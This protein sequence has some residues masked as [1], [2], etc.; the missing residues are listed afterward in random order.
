M[1]KEDLRKIIQTNTI[2]IEALMNSAL[3]G[4]DARQYKAILSRLR[5]GQAP[6]WFEVLAKHGALPNLD[7]KTIGSVIEA[8]LVA[9]IETHILRSHD[10][11][12]LRINPA[13][14]VDLPD[15]DLGVKS[16][17]TNWCT[18]EPFFSAY[19]RL[20]GSEYD[21][22]ILLTNYQTAKKSPPLKLQILSTN[23][24]IASEIADYG[25]C[26]IAKKFR[27]EMVGEFNSAFE[28]RFKQLCTFL[29]YVN[30][31]DWRGKRLLGLIPLIKNP[32]AIKT[33]IRMA[34]LDF[35]RKSAESERK[36]SPRIP[37]S[38]L[39]ALNLILKI[40]P[41]SIGV[42]DALAQWLMDMIKDAARPPNDN[43][44]KRLLSGPLCGKI[45]MSFALQW[46]YNFKK[47]FPEIKRGK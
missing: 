29:A 4:S 33:S 13:R 3:S 23:Y 15:L 26:R 6:H 24:L 30:Q 39:D 17:S 34:N 38:D 8:L 28:F 21:A 20:T 9:V 11:P 1:K 5:G 14:G 22:L 10:C 47:V 45:G 7:G 12:K 37:D 19:E 25:L 16:P 44:F 41:I 43:E 36:G 42:M 35:G 18:S 40:N 2:Q 27:K 32:E 46:R 31:S